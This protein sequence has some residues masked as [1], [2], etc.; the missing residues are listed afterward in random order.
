MVILMLL[1]FPQEWRCIHEQQ[2]VVDRRTLVIA[3]AM[4]FSKTLAAT[5][6]AHGFKSA[7]SSSPATITTDD[8]LVT[9]ELS[10]TFNAI[11]GSGDRRRS[12][13]SPP[14]SEFN[15]LILPKF[16]LGFSDDY[17]WLK[18]TGEKTVHGWDNLTITAKY[19][20][21][22]MATLTP[23]SSPSSLPNP[24]N[25]RHRKPQHRTRNSFSTFTP[26]LYFGKGFS[27]L[28]DALNFFKPIAITGTLGLNFP[29]EAA[30]PNS[31]EWGLA[32]EYNL[33]Y[34]H[35]HIQD[36]GLPEPFKN[37]IPLVEFAGDSPFNRDGGITTLTI[38]PGVLWE[39]RYAQ[40][41]LEALIPVNHESGTHI[42][43]IL[44]MQVYID[45]LLPKL[46][47]GPI[48]GG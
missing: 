44:Q 24:R 1:S 39:S 13:L 5:S 18:P 45:D 32:L 27:D 31:L 3:G 8:P 14:A 22:R 12:R 21:W 15:K 40:I 10:F 9:D 43:G 46:F 34:Y 42:G 36:L 6:A 41:G 33:P 47:G 37:M 26:T 29:T 35:Q 28:P 2:T 7:I 11:P 23:P 16:T 38:N 20:I 17:A 48:F 30:D 19:E 4:G 25:R